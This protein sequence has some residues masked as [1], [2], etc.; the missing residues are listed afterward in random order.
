MARPWWEWPITTPENPIG[1]WWCF[2]APFAETWWLTTW[3]C[4]WTWC[5]GWWWP[6]WWFWLFVLALLLFCC[7]AACR[8]EFFLFFIRLFWNH[9]F[10][11]RSVRFKFRANSHRF[12]LETY[13]LN[14]NSFSSSSVWNLEYGLRFFRT[15]TWP[16]HS[17]G[18]P[19]PHGTLTPIE[20]REPEQK[21][22]DGD[23]PHRTLNNYVFC[24]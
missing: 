16:V 3:C 10:T 19:V 20:P 11:W 21:K 18:F 23:D 5:A 7:C 9:I 4:E 17:K 6:P 1:H 13:A 8:W 14:R 24:R 15:V 12:C 2:S 22:P